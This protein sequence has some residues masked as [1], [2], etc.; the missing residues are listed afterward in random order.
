M[1][2]FEDSGEQKL[3]EQDL[4]EFETLIGNRLPQD[5]KNH[6]LIYNGGYPDAESAYF[7]NID[8]DICLSSL[9]H[10][11]GND[12]DL[13][14]DMHKTYD[15]LPNGIHIGYILGGGLS[16]SLEP[17]EHGSIY[18]HYSETVSPIKIAKSF[19]EFISG[20]KDYGEVY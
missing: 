1:I 11:K 12:D 4:Q 6:M 18:I 9:H 7:G 3:T 16:M 8:N 10:L 17:N 15:R 13:L 2:K 5:Y 19:T 14:I 20:L